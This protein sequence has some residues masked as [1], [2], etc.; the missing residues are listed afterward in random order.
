MNLSNTLSDGMVLQRAPAKAVVWGLASPG[1]PVTTQFEG[2]ML[3]T[4]TDQSGVWRQVLPPMEATSDGRTLT[5]NSTEGSA[6]LRGV[7]FGEV[8]LCGGQSNMAYTPHSMAGMNNATAE[9]AAADSDATT[10]CGCSQ[11]VRGP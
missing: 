4:T 7:L 3:T 5:F 10:T 9:I 8:F 11:W 2:R 1:L 6:E